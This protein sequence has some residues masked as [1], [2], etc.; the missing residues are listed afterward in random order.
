[1]AMAPIW[2]SESVRSCRRSPPRPLHLHDQQ[3]LQETQGGLGPLQ[4]AKP[5][6]CAGCPPAPA[7]SSSCGARAS[8]G[9]LVSPHLTPGEAQLG[10]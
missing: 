6:L 3:S 10:P 5:S 8:P 9:M 4:D 1:M 7:G 2:P